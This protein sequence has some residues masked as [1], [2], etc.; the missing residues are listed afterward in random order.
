MP[1]EGL[2]WYRRPDGSLVSHDGISSLL[3]IPAELRTADR[4]M[5]ERV[6]EG[7]KYLVFRY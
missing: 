2:L 6:I 5:T 4:R 1:E 3:A 7:K